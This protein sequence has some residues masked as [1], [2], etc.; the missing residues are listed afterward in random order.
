MDVPDGLLLLLLSALLLAI[1][2]WRFE[3]R[4]S[5]A[6]RADAIEHQS[7]GK[8]RSTRYG[9]LTERFAPWMAAWPFDDPGRFRF[10]GD[11]IDGVQFEEDAIY[12][13][14]IKTADSA[15]KPAQAA[16]RNAI[17]NGRVGW[18]QFN[19][20]EQRETERIEPWKR[21]SR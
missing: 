21:A 8:S 6:A 10:L 14:E 3:A 2:L 9:K 20:H 12:V 11:P 4:R 1:G 15:L 7:R 13:V 5:R 18:V 19:V 16:V 17:L